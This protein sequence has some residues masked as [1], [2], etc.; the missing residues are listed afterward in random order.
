MLKK[1]G[2]IA[3]ALLGIA[4]LVGGCGNAQRDATDAAISA[5]QA[6]INSVAGEAE[7]YV[8]DQLQAAQAALQR[9]KDALAKEDYQSALSE[10]QDAANRAKDLTV[11]AAAK[12]DELNKG[13]ADLNASVP[14]TLDA[15]KVRL[16]AYAH[17][18]RLP[19]GLERDQLEGVKA[20]YDQL[21][22]SWADASAA[23]TQGNLG[24]AL[25]RASA[26]QDAL[27][28]LR[29]LLGMKS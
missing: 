11:A 22:Q 20:Q 25:K 12:K 19:A 29:E 26:V 3:C 24:D 9:A 5:T 10:V 21:K 27:A 17:G 4:L 28:K 1:T 23:A 6:A 13:W 15:V 7:K 14:K 16:Y 2:W 18:A 8:P